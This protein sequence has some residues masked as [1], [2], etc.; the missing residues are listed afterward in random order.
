MGDTCP[1]C[2]TPTPDSDAAKLALVRKRVDA[3]DPKANNVLADICYRGNYGLK[4]D[5]PRSF[6]LWTEAARLGDKD[7]HC[8]IGFLYFNGKGV[9]KDVA[10]GIRHWQQAAIHGHPESR[11]MLGFHENDVGNHDLAVQHWMISANMGCEKSLNGIKDI[12]MKGHATKAQYAEVLRGY[13]N[14]LEETKSPQQKGLHSARLSA[15]QDPGSYLGLTFPGEGRGR[16]E[17][18]QL[19]PT[20]GEAAWPPP[21]PHGETAP[22]T[23][24]RRS[25]SKL[26]YS[27]RVST[28][29]IAPPGS[30]HEKNRPRAL[31]RSRVARPT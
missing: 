22:S 4:I 15:V 28:A 24:V 11:F 30:S 31:K 1:F 20:N 23:D 9:E 25:P 7:G 21:Y 16:M 18:L 3:K 19:P 27:R 6:D 12:F 8:R 13:Q 14:A 2:R 29:V 5:I 26:E 17:V 10:R